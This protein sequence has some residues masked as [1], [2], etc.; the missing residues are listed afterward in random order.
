MSRTPVI[1]VHG[2]AGAH[3]LITQCGIPRDVIEQGVSQAARTAYQILTAGGTAVEAVEAAVVS[4]EDN[5]VFNAG[6]Y[7]FFHQ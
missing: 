2:G 5:P 4:M 6:L 7:F 1:V 3:A